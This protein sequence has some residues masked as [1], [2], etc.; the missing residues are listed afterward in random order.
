MLTRFIMNSYKAFSEIVLWL[1]LL[2]CVIGGAV[3]GSVLVSFSSSS[4]FDPNPSSFSFL[5]IV[6]GAGIGF[7]VWLVVAVM[8]FGSILMVLDIRQI[9]KKIAASN[10]KPIS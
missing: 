8:F 3:I 5:G 2:F 7:V 6:L 9:C 1:L 10:K 4:F